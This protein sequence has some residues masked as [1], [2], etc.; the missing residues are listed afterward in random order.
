MSDPGQLVL[1]GNKIDLEKDR[2]V[3]WSRGKALADKY[4]IKFI[5]VSAKTGENVQN[6]FSILGA[7]IMKDLVSGKHKAPIRSMKLQNLAG[8]QEKVKCNRC[9]C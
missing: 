8:E 2:V 1:V 3:S 7:E 9:A 6:I 4:S 5:E